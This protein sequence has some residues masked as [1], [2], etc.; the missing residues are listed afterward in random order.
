MSDKQRMKTD[1]RQLTILRRQHNDVA[2]YLKVKYQ[3]GDV[4]LDNVENVLAAMILNSEQ[5]DRAA[6]HGS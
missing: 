2:A 1:L 5:Q 3:M 6:E 4:C